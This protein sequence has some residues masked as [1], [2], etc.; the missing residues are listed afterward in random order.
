MVR[1]AAR[2]PGGRMKTLREMRAARVPGPAAVSARGAGTAAPSLRG[3]EGGS[4][5][6]KLD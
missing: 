3:G 6:V 4:S 5:Y 1:A 2:D